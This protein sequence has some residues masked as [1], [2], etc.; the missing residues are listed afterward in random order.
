MGN[1]CS[2]VATDNLSCPSAQKMTHSSDDEFSYSFR[3][4]PSA[5]WSVARQAVPRDLASLLR[6]KLAAESSWQ[7]R[8]CACM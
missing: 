6:Q 3:P 4:P 8:A 1:S 2:A 7:V 5:P